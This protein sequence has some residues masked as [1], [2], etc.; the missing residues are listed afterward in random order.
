MPILTFEVQPR[1][2]PDTPMWG[3]SQGPFTFIISRESEA[4]P[5][6]GNYVASVKEVGLRPFEGERVDLGWFPNFSKAKKAC[7][8]FYKMKVS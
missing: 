2:F 7:E 1:V 6:K 5:G 4:E 3:A 8:R